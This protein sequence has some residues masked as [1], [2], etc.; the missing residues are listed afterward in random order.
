[1]TDLDALVSP[2][3]HGSDTFARYKYQAHVTFPY[4]LELVTGEKVTDLFTEHVEDIAVLKSGTW[5]FLQVKSR[6]AERGPWTFSDVLDSGAFH[7]LWRAYQT[8]AGTFEAAY[9]ICVEGT[10]RKDDP[11]QSLADGNGLDDPSLARV[12]AKFGATAED[13]R[14]F[15]DRVQ[16]RF[17][18]SLDAVAAQNISLLIRKAPGVAGGDIEQTYL[19]AIATIES[20]MTANRLDG[21]WPAALF[22]APDE[23]MQARL[24]RKRITRERAEDLLEPI[25]R[26]SSSSPVV[27]T[28]HGPRVV[29]PPVNLQ[30]FTGRSSELQR[31]E[32]L[33]L[34]TS[35]EK[36]TSIA[37]VSGSGGIGKSA[38]ACRFAELHQSNFPD[39]VIGLRV[40][41][42]E[43][44]SIARDFAARAGVEIEEDDERDASTIMQEVFRDRRALLILD[45]ADDVAI[46]ALLPGGTRCAVII[47]TRDRGL[48]AALGVPAEAQF[49]LSPLPLDE[50]LELLER[51]A[52]SRVAAN[53]PAAKRVCESVG[54]LPLALQIA[55]ATL[56]IQPLRSVDDY[57]GALA[58]ERQRLS[59]LTFAGDAALDVRASFSLSLRLLEP[60][61]IDFFAALSVCAPDGFSL[62]AAAAANGCDEPAAQEQITSLFALCLVNVNFV[63]ARYVLHPP[64]PPVRAGAGGGKRRTDDGGHAASR[65][66]CGSS[67]DQGGRQGRGGVAGPRDRRHSR[68]RRIDVPQRRARLR[69]RHSSSAVFPAVRLLG[70]GRKHLCGVSP[71]SGRCARLVRGR[72]ASAATSEISDVPGKTRRGGPGCRRARS[73]HRSRRAGIEPQASHGH[74]ANYT[75]RR[76]ATERR[77]GRC[78]RRLPHDQGPT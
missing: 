63:D 68:C 13:V 18:P 37:G 53:L 75:R 30:A 16:M 35:G 42:R 44:A 29:L 15:A 74:V 19:A 23:R 5:R 28:S 25:L 11:L 20:A 34:R 62:M 41:G 32:A 7:S 1:M 2:D 59:L 52:G 61:E 43:P 38:L 4:V 6:N 14:P 22:L 67:Q 48:P 40:D 50:A 39:G 69:L 49:D 24:A 9:E 57:A 64:D 45:N 3:D 51:I 8:A 36:I 47:T 73:V 70:K 21:D 27:Q 54:N 12:A 60:A 66:L 17:L 55:G 56:R 31:L 72:P 71:R 77:F 10:L 33:L 46:R 26:A 65:L 76:I 78:T 58:E